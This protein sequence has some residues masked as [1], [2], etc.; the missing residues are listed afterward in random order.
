MLRKLFLSIF[1]VAG[2][3]VLGVH[4]VNALQTVVGQDNPTVDV[5]AVQA[6]V[7]QG[8]EILL[9]KTFDFGEKGSVIINKDV[10]IVGEKDGQGV[11]TT[12]I[13]GGSRTFFKPSPCPVAS[14]D[15]WAEHCH[16]KHPV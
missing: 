14:N 1:L 9:K 4:S 11:P 8:G 12:K 6:A 16:S 2:L 3:F 15:T 13:K 5:Q 7:S 10:K